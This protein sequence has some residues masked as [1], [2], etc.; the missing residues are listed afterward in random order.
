MAGGSSTP[1]K[2]LPSFRLS[3]DVKTK[4]IN[5]LSGLTHQRECCFTATDDLRDVG[6][7][8]VKLVGPEFPFYALR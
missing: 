1:L 2:G 3:G 7:L 4:T 6:I 5:A 8:V